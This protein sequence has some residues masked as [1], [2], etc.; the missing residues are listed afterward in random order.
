LGYFV[1]VHKGLKKAVPPLF[2]CLKKR[3]SFSKMLRKLAS[4]WLGKKEGTTAIEFSLL[5]IPYLMLTLATIE[6]SIMY[7]SASLLEG[8]TGSAARMI[9]TGQLQQGGG[10]PES[11]FR[12]AMCNY[13]TVLIKCDDIVIEVQPMDSFADA[14]EMEP[15]YD[16]DG[17]L[18]SNGFDAGG[19]SDRVLIRVAYRYHMMTPFVGPLLAGPTNS[20]LFMSTIVLQVEPYDFEGSSS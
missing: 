13:A 14:E 6:L 12:T 5:V 10:D 4:A 11:V 7:A 18:I 16:E 8:A 2:L 17:N 9:R 20:R 3:K 15:Q 1:H 19:S